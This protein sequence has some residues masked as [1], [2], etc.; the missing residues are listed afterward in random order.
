VPRAVLVVLVA[1]GLVASVGCSP[2][3]PAP[4]AASEDDASDGSWPPGT[5]PQVR[6]ADLEQELV[7]RVEA[8][9]TAG[10]SLVV[11]QDG[12]V[13]ARSDVG[14]F[15]PTTVVPVGEAA[16]WLTAVVVATLVDGGLVGLDDPVADHLPGFAGDDVADRDRKRDVTVRQLLSHTSGLPGS[17]G[18]PTDPSGAGATATVAEPVAPV[19]PQHPCDDAVDDASLLDGPG[20]RFVVS[21][22]GYHVLARLVEDVTGRSWPEAVADRL[23]GPLAMSATTVPGSGGVDDVT[24][25]GS[26]ADSSGADLGRFL[27]M[28]LAGGVGAAGSRVVSAEVLSEMER[29]QTTKLDTHLEPWVAWTGI[30]TFGLGVW[31][32][33]LR[34]DGTGAS[35]SAAGG[36]GTYPWIDRPRNV[37]GVLVMDDRASPPGEAV[38]FSAGL[39]QGQVPP[40]VETEGRAVYRVPARPGGDPTRDGDAVEDGDDESIVVTDDASGG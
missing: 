39:V 4:E 8:V 9:G 26:T 21:T 13:L 22:A 35:V 14:S 33:R 19:W 1:V 12:A 34:G 30:P 2:D 28:V 15:D 6:F 11:V 40:A 23:T 18:C 25:L 29:D 37:W 16:R 32:D 36:T 5:Y 3:G 38:R 10:A 20:D 31:R 17:L 24:S 7:R 27:A